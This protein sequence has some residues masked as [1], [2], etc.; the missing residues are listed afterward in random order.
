MYKIPVQKLVEWIV[1]VNMTAPNVHVEVFVHKAERLQED[2]KMEN[3]RQ[4]DGWIQDRL[5]DE[6]DQYE[7]M[8]IGFYITS[9]YDHSLHDAF[10]RVLHKLVESLPHQEELLNNFC[11]VSPFHP[12]P[13]TS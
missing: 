4:I 11:A 3:F 13:N 10:S 1:A 5:S 6:G 12:L 2:D 7:N 8:Q 9:V